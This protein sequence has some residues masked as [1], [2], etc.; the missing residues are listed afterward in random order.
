MSERTCGLDGCTKTFYARGMCKMHYMRVSRNGHPN[1]TRAKGSCSVAGCERPHE[2]H[3]LCD[4]HYNRT[5]P[6]AECS[7]ENCSHGVKGHGLCPKHL[8]RQETHGDARREPYAPRC[9]VE[10]CGLAI[11]SAGADLCEKHYSRQRRTGTTEPRQP[12]MRCRNS[13]G[14]VLVKAADHPNANTKGWIFEH[15]LNLSRHLGRPLREG[16]TVHHKNGVRDDNRIENLELW[17]GA[18]RTHRHGVRVSDLVKDA[19]AI[20]DEY[21]PH[22]LATNTR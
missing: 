15:R 19:L 21:A 6:R 10:D 22:L 16:E 18:G 8:R 11:R 4:L 13:H 2:A 5:R 14:Y 12:A 1:I 3:G 9:Q 20:L 17:V 7:V